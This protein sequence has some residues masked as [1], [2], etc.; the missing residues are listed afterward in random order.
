M[1]LMSATAWLERAYQAHTHHLPESE[2]AKLRVVNLLALIGLGLSLTYTLL[3]GVVF[4]SPMAA[5]LNLLF[6]SG[7]VAYFGVL[8]L[9]AVNASRIW[10][11]GVYLVQMAIFSL[12]VFPPE[13]GLHLFV[14]AG[15]PLAFLV[16][17]HHDRLLRAGTVLL[18]L[19]VFFLAE[20]LDTPKLLDHLPHAY[21][22]TTYL[23]VVP[24]ITLLVAIVLQS[25]LSELHRR[26]EA[27]RQLSV[28]DPLTGVAN[29]RGLLERAESMQAQA[30]RLSLP[31]CVVMMDIDHF[32][33]V[34]DDHG[35]QTG[36]H[37]LAAVARALRDNIRKEDAIGRMGGEEFA[38]LLSNATLAE[39]LQTAEHLRK[40][41]GSVQVSGGKGR[42]LGCTAS[43]GVTALAESEGS[44]S[45]ALA[46]ADKAL[47]RAKA[48]GRNRVCGVQPA[49]SQTG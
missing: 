35:H 38:L 19:A 27:L 28:T 10:L 12:W 48:E 49:L 36:D 9:G 30:S 1:T 31:M 15:I 17:G 37:L 32:K 8:H 5:G 23:T 29:R 24:L 20:T 16:F 7:Y 26:D 47:Y 34:N 46:R 21:Y 18:L 2:R 22:R 39:G 13:S 11:V 40:Q 41:V 3:Y 43:F 14:I 45:R 4:Q 42:P 33:A 6:V 25:F 44:V